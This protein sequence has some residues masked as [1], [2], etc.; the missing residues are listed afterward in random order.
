MNICFEQLG[1]GEDPKQLI[2]FI[3]NLH[4]SLFELEPRKRLEYISRNMLLC[5]NAEKIRYILEEFQKYTITELAA[6]PRVDKREAKAE[7]HTGRYVGIEWVMEEFGVARQTVY[8]WVHRRLIPCKKIG[9]QL[10]F[11]KHELYACANTL[12][13]ETLEELKQKAIQNLSKNR[14]KK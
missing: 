10:L 1:D 2:E 4:K 5:K 8:G 12:R 13:I 9:K 3:N 14:K 11:E 7:K 6:E